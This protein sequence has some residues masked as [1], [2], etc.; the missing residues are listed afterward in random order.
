MGACICCCE[1]KCMLLTA[2]IIGLWATLISVKVC[3]MMLWSKTLPKYKWQQQQQEL[4]KT[5]ELMYVQAVDAERGICGLARVCV[6]VIVKCVCG[7]RLGGRLAG[8]R[9]VFV[10]VCLL[11]Q[12]CPGGGAVSGKTLLCPAHS[13]VHLS[14]TSNQ[15]QFKQ[16]SSACH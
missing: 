7:G 2:M 3:C 15:E 4:E 12:S 14:T 13:A 6:Q 11:C 8:S 10:L 5:R 1:C 16:A 9:G